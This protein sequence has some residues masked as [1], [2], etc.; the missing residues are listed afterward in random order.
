MTNEQRPRMMPVHSPILQ[1]RQ[2]LR[3]AEAENAN[4]RELLNKSMTENVELLRQVVVM[5]EAL[6]EAQGALLSANKRVDQLT[7]ALIDTGDALFK[8]YILAF[9]VRAVAPS[10]EEL[11]R[12]CETLNKT[13]GAHGG[14]IITLR[15]QLAGAQAAHHSAMFLLDAVQGDCNEWHDAYVALLRWSQAAYKRLGGLMAIG[16]S[17]TPDAV[18]AALLDGAPANVSAEVDPFG[19]ELAA[20]L[21]CTERDVYEY[22]VDSMGASG[23]KTVEGCHSAGLHSCYGELWLCQECGNFFCDAEGSDNMPELCN[24]CWFKAQGE[25]K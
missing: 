6:Y 17:M 4:L 19:A 11:E 14:E 10:M 23:I 9:A 25:A 24:D 18:T 20:D 12:A 16:V 5:Q 22:A 3:D 1:V 21:N 2:N 8:N 7:T 15:Q 13:P